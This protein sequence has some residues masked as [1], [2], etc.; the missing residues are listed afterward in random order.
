MSITR[1]TDMLEV[2]LDKQLEDIPAETQERAA[3]LIADTLFAA[4]FG[5]LAPELKAYLYE[6]GIEAQDTVHS[7]PLLGTGL[8]ASRVQ[9]VM[10]YGTAIVNN[11]LDEGNQ[12]AKGHPAAHML[13]PA[14]ITALEQKSS[15]AEMIRAFVIGYEVAARLA[16]ASNMN[17]DMHPHGTWGIVGGAVAAGLLQK[18]GKKEIAEAV[19]LA[20]SL[21]IATSWEAAVTGMTVRNLYT[22]VGSFLALQAWTFQAAGFASSAHVV[23]HLWGSILS[24]GINYELFHKELWAPPLLSKNYFKLYPSCR[25]SHS[26]IDALL[27]LLQELKPDVS[28]IE[29]VQVETYGLAA[30]LDYPDPANALAAKFSIPFLLSVLVHGHSLYD[31]FAGE[32]F[33]DDSVREL[34]KRIVVTEDKEM[35]ALLPAKRAARVTITTRDG[36]GCSYYV[37]AASGGYEQPFPSQELRDK[38]A[39]MLSQ[40]GEQKSSRMVEEALLL[41]EAA[42]VSEWLERINRLTAKG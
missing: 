20:A 15:G 33:H 27:P 19:L 11:E 9:A 14:L 32:L 17:D 37:D 13:A 26:A 29:S 22:G 12:F 3:W 7:I 25:F 2:L 8:Y 30:R 24:K 31:C 23:D 18:K 35:T 4:S 40:W 38:F 16:Y 34:A 42:M 41:P 28:Q 36:A 6:V 39:S 5:F 10:L 1:F 21:P